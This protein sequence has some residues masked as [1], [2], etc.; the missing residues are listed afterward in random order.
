MWS[1][2]SPKVAPRFV[3]PIELKRDVIASG[4]LGHRGLKRGYA[5]SKGQPNYHNIGRIAFPGV[6]GMRTRVGVFQTSPS[7]RTE[8]QDAVAAAEQPARCGQRQVDGGG[9]GIRGRG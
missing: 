4:T 3:P 7:D 5:S 2:S 8:R 9:A 1:A 6:R